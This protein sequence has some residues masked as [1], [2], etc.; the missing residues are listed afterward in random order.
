MKYKEDQ[1]VKLLDDN[2]LDILALKEIWLRP[3][4]ANQTKI[5]ALSPR[6][7][8]FDHKPRSDITGG[9]ICVNYLESK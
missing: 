1:V 3:G 8:K 2:E 9:G 6:S 4:D 7:V 5:N